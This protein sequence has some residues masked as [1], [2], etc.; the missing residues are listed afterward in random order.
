MLDLT[1]DLGN[2]DFI[3]LAYLLSLFFSYSFLIA[4]FNHLDKMHI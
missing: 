1:F 2:I 3:H 4:L